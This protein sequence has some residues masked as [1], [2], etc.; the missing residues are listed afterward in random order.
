MPSCD[1]SFKKKKRKRK[2]AFL[3]QLLQ[4]KFHVTISLAKVGNMSITG[5]R[6]KINPTQMTDVKNGDCLKGNWLTVTKSDGR[7]VIG[8][9]KITDIH[10]SRLDL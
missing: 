2:R 3:S 8:K 6:G 4:L 7:R 9:G 1:W 10:V 5:A